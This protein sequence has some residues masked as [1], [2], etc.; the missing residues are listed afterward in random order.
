M[1]KT[2]EGKGRDGAYHFSTGPETIY[3]RTYQDANWTQSSV[4]VSRGT[5]VSLSSTD[6]DYTID[7]EQARNDLEEIALLHQQDTRELVRVIETT[8]NGHLHRTFVYKYVLADGRETT[9]GEGPDSEERRSPAQIERD[10]EEIERLHRRGERELVGVIET[11][12]EGKIDRTC[13]Y[14]YLLA[15][16]REITGGEGDPEQT[17]PTRSLSVE[18]IKEIWRL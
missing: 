3:E 17:P 5:G 14:K 6:P 13:K 15:D 7:V 9:M 10:F 1:K 12:V 2:F 8:V 16:G 11:E 18:Q 4:G